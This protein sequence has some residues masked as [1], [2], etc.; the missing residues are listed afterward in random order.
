MKTKIV[1]IVLLLLAGCVIGASFMGLSVVV[2][3]KTSSDKYCISCHTNHSLVP[4]NPQFSHLY[5][6]KG[7]TVK[8]ADCHIAPGIGNYLKAKAGGFKDVFTYM[9]NGDFNTK[10]W[11]DKHRSELAEKALSDIAK[12]SSASCIECHSKIKSDLPKDMEPLARE[13]H[14]YNNAKSVEDQ[15]QCIYCHRGVAHHYNK[16]WA[17]KHTESIKNN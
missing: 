5:N 14:Q 15:K 16:E 7:I 6:S 3:H 13:I 9:F 12:T 17:T 2:M 4:D 10:E 1:Q 11:I 8:C